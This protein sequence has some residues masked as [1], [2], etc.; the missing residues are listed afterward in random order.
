[1]ARRGTKIDS[2]LII[3]ALVAAP[4]IWL[5]DKLG[6]GAFVILIAVIAVIF[7]ANSSKKKKRPQKRNGG[8]K[9][10]KT[11]KIQHD[12]V[13]RVLAALDRMDTKD[14]L[15]KAAEEGHKAKSAIDAGDFDGA[16]KHYHEQKSQYLQH[17]KRSEFTPAQTIALDGSVNR[18][19]ANIL[20]IQGKH[21][22]A[23]THYLYYYATT[24]RKTKTDEKQILTYYNRARIK[25]VT[26][27]EVR[28]Y[29]E[30]QSTKPD[31]RAIQSACDAWVRG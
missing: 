15:G 4:F 21:T 22:L 8:R 12:D 26:F 19:L 1:M 31:F 9:P 23:L 3:A 6:S 28:D 2:R 14:Y 13:D 16:W 5:F 30:K 7:F 27:E 18:S 25:S 29:A 10:Q 20:R 17:A 24:S 11:V